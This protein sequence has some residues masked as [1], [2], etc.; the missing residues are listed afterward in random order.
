MS[1]RKRLFIFCFVLT[2]FQVFS[3]YVSDLYGAVFENIGVG[4]RAKGMGDAYTAAADDVYSVYWNPAGLMHV[5]DTYLSFMHRD[6][7]CSTRMGISYQRI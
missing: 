4:P 7:C 2:V 6:L 5:D 3:L 1:I